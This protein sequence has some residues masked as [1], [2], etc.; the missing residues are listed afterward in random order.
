MQENGAKVY[1]CTTFPALGLGWT[2]LGGN[3]MWV[4]MHDK[5]FLCPTP[6][7]Q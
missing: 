4:T 3:N 5:A 6:N 1:C 2:K 7:A